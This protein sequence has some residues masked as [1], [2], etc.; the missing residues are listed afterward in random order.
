MADEKS[1]KGDGSGEGL[2][3]KFGGAAAAGVPPL[4]LV[5][6]GNTFG[7]F[8]PWKENHL[9]STVSDFKRESRLTSPKLRRVKKRRKVSTAS[10]I[11]ANLVCSP[12]AWTAGTPSSNS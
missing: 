4:T 7:S 6:A 3:L 10:F 12:S 11:L 1:K 5:E 9:V 2:V 8:P